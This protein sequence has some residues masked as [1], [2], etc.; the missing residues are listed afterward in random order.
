MTSDSA[1]GTSGDANA[2]TDGAAHWV[3]T[4]LRGA[5]DLAV[6]AYAHG[7]GADNAHTVVGNMALLV[8]AL[9]TALSAW[10]VFREV[11][12]IGFKVLKV[13]L[14]G[15]LVLLLGSAL[16][17]LFAFVYPT[18]AA[19]DEARALAKAAVDTSSTWFVERVWRRYA[20]G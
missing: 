4:S 19:K 14:M 10:Y 7:F 2:L 3:Q 11:A 18:A 8:L 6:R 13:V 20:V 5:Y 1:A 15:A 17:S 16:S 12:E 9:V